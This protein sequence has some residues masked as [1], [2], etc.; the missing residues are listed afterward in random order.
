MKVC[1]NC[2]N[3][4]EDELVFCPNCGG[5]MDGGVQPSQNISNGVQ[6]AQ[7]VPGVADAAAAGMPEAQPAPGMPGAQPAPG[8]P[9]AQPAPGMPGAQPAPGMPGAQPAPGMPGAQP[10]PKEKKSLVPILIIVLIVVVV[11]C[12]VFGII[13]FNK[14]DTGS[15]KESDVASP[16]PVST[17]TSNVAKYAGFEFT[18]PD[19]YVSDTDDEF[20]LVI[21][22]SKVVYT[23]FPDYTNSFDAYYKAYSEKF[24]TEVDKLKKEINGHK[25]ILIALTDSNGDTGVEYV[26]DSGKGYLFVGVVINSTYTTPTN[27]ELNTLDKILASAKSG[28]TFAPGD[29]ND[30]GKS[31]IL[32]LKLNKDL[33]K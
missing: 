20:G 29:D 5:R 3:Q 32:D 13:M 21:T 16:T 24:P 28:S 14:K 2:G 33:L 1:P 15:G 6:P 11:L 22:N 26:Y 17:T 12:S 31:G 27:E 30:A 23:V 10:A 25:Y 9:G 8:M 4:V 19:D 7:P 18:L